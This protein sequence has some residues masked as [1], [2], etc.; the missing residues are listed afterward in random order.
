M[1]YDPGMCDTFTTCEPPM[2]YWWTSATTSDWRFYMGD[3]DIT[4]TIDINATDD[5]LLAGILRRAVSRS[6]VTGAAVW[7]AD[8]GGIHL[9]IN[10]LQITRVEW[11]TLQRVARQP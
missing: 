10:K 11:D 3:Q 1:T 8:N 2:P 6:A 7:S 5:V 4:N 9:T